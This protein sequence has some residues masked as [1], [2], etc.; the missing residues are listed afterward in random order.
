[1]PQD[2]SGLVSLCVCLCVCWC[3]CLFAAPWPAL[4][5][6][7]CR[8]GVCRIPSGRHHLCA[9]TC[10]C[11]CSCD[12]NCDVCSWSLAFEPHRS[13]FQ[14]SSASFANS[15]A[16]RVSAPARPP[17]F[18]SAQH[19]MHSASSLPHTAAIAD[20]VGGRS[21]SIRWRWRRRRRLSSPHLRPLPLPSQPGFGR[22]RAAPWPLRS[23][24][25]A[26][27]MPGACAVRPQTARG[28]AGG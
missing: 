13:A 9:R 7:C 11:A 26:G 20:P 8:T 14:M 24:A 6:R 19:T 27:A 2:G 4:V 23:P 10:A 17:P 22:C 21:A 28:R 15:P 18:P 12:C 3:V 5:F 1:M 16:Q 25:L